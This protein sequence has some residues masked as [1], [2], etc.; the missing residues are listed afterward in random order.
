M[1]D[2]KQNRTDKTFSFIKPNNSL[3]EIIIKCE[4]RGLNAEDIECDVYCCGYGLLECKYQWC[5][6]GYPYHEQV[7]FIDR[8]TG[9]L[10]RVKEGTIKDERLD[11]N[12]KQ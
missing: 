4:K 12:Q 9:E 11:P 10:N 1:S 7:E 5:E 2:C 8:Q 3:E 6:N